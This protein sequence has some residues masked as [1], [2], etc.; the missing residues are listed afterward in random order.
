MALWV[1]VALVSDPTWSSLLILGMLAVLG[2]GIAGGLAWD[3]LTA[4]RQA[5][6]GSG[7]IE[8]RQWD[9]E[10]KYGVIIISGEVQNSSGRDLHGVTV[11]VKMFNQARQIVHTEHRLTSPRDVAAWGSA[12][13]E[14]YI[15]RPP[16]ATWIE[17]EKVTWR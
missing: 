4:Y 10:E 5:R 15:R 13:F 7:D 11:Y 14:F 9:W 12:A 3:G 2:L 17:I 6:N 8:L 16:D 1:P